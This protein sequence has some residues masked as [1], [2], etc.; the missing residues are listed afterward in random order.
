MK[1]E[2]IRHLVDAG[3]FT[4]TSIW[5]RIEQD[6]RKGIE[7]VAWSVTVLEELGWRLGKRFR[8]AKKRRRSNVPASWTPCW[9]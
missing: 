3:P 1:L 6:L 7:A 9:T 8:L 2:Q 4:A 5:E